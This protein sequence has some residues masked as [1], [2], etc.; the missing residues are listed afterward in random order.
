MK[1]YA[2]MFAVALV[3][4]YAANRVAVVNKYVGPKAA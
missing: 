4:V 2:I 3:A 1:K